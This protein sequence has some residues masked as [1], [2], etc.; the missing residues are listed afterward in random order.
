MTFSEW[1]KVQIDALRAIIVPDDDPP[2]PPPEGVEQIVDGKSIILRFQS[3]PANLSRVRK[4]IESFCRQTQLQP[5]A[6]DEVGLV[7]NEALANVIRH[8]YD[9]A[10]NKPIEVKADLFETGLKIH[11]RDWGNG[12]DPSQQ[13]RPT[14][15]P[16]VPG[17][18]GLICMKHLMDEFRFVPQSDGMLLE[19][20]RTTPTSKAE[21][22]NP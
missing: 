7:V 21:K 6:C 11:I 16:L 13:P 17:G 19:L 5:A 10:E 14:H 1:I 18:L 8:A 12:Q 9:N 15:D 22:I 2:P 3:S 20:T 4:A